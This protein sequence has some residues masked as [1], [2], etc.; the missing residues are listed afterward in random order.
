[1]VS[2]N[3]AATKTALPK[4]STAIAKTLITVTVTFMNYA[5]SRP[6]PMDL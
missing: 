2:E 6:I 1:V 4:M 5:A 3:S